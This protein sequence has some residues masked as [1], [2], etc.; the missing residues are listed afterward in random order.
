MRVQRVISFS[1]FLRMRNTSRQTYLLRP[2]RILI[3]QLIQAGWY[4]DCNCN[5]NTD[6]NA[7]ICCPSKNHLSHPT[8][9]QFALHAAYLVASHLILQYRIASHH[10]LRCYTVSC[11]GTIRLQPTHV[12][13]IRIGSKN[14]R[15]EKF[16]GLPLHRG[17]SYL[18]SKSRL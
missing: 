10:V 18:K 1:V 5:A 14:P 3:V 7:H 13:R 15:V 4:C 6:T 11:S 12:A 17:I 2:P 16:E 9:M 8:M